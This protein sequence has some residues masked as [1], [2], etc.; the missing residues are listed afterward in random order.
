MGL[1]RSEAAAFTMGRVVAG[2]PRWIVEGARPPAPSRRMKA[3]ALHSADAFRMAAGDAGK[4][5]V[6]S[7]APR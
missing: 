5:L 2:W 7:S 4:P 3:M 1:R 6:E